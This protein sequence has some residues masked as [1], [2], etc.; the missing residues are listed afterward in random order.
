MN[1][2]FSN[3]VYIYPTDTVWG[4]GASIF[5]EEGTRL[6]RKIKGNSQDKPLSVLFS[7]FAGLNEFIEIPNELAKYDFMK[8]FSMEATVGF[9]KEWFKKDI[10]T[11]VTSNSNIVAVRVL[12]FSFLSDIISKEGG[13]ITTT[14]LNK[15]SENPITDFSLAKRFYLSE[16]E[17]L[18]D[19]NFVEG[20][21]CRPSGRSSS[22]IFFDVNHK[23]KIIR[24]GKFID[25]LQ[26]LLR[27]SP[28]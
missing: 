17:S 4:I 18:E 24:E 19:V 11:W 26:K 2:I 6:V 27:I 22:M 15:A 9:P 8:V 28:T 3:G 12:E 5:S 25:E 20:E 13:A 16:K 21:E 7:S 10:P 1:K 14:S 23:I